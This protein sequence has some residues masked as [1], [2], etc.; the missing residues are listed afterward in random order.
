MLTGVAVYTSEAVVKITAGK[1]GIDGFV[2][3]GAPC[4]VGGFVFCCVDSPEL[5]EVIG[6]KTVK[7]AV[8]RVPLAIYGRGRARGNIDAGT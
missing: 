5:I 4:A 8:A 3:V 7:R 6:D 2:P 1:K